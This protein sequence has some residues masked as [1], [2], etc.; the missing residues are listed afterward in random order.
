MQMLINMGASTAAV[1]STFAE[2]YSQNLNRNSVPSKNFQ[3]S[4]VSHSTLSLNP[5]KYDVIIPDWQ[6][7][8]NCSKNVKHIFNNSHMVGKNLCHL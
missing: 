2:V 8:C 7:I 5:F 3:I 6:W 1:L 4:Y